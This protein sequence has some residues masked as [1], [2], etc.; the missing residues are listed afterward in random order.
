MEKDKLAFAALLA[1]VLVLLAPVLS[2]PG[3]VPGNFGDLFAYHY[4]L[5]QL[6]ASRLQSGAFPLWNPYIF[7]GLP[8]FANS[9]AATVYPGSVLFHILPLSAAFTFSMLLHLV[10]AGAGTYLL[11]RELR[12]ARWAATALAFS[13]MLSPFVAFRGAHGVPTLLCSLAYVPWTWLAL[14]AGAWRL[15]ALVFVLQFLSG[16]PQFMAANILGLGAVALFNGARPLRTLAAGGLVALALGAVQIVE[17]LRFSG[18]SVRTVWP[19][20]FASGYDWN[21][22]SW[23]SLVH[24]F[25]AG[26]PLMNDPRMLGTYQNLPS[27]FFETGI[28][29]AG[30][31][32]LA[33]AAWGARGARW[34]T[35]AVFVGLA[36]LGVGLALGVR[37][38]LYTF[39][40]EHTPL[41]MFRVPARFGLLVVWSVVLAAAWGLREFARRVPRRAWRAAALAFVCVDLVATD[42]PYFYAQ[43]PE[44]FIAP[45]AEVL[46]LGPDAAVAMG[47]K[48]AAPNKAMLY[49]QRGASGYEAYYLASAALYHGRSQRGPAADASKLYLTRGDTPEMR[50]LGIRRLIGEHPA[51]FDDAW[52]PA[53]LLPRDARARVPDAASPLGSARVVASAP[54]G[55]RVRVDAP[56]GPPAALVFAAAAYPG[57]KA[58]VRTA[59]GARAEDVVPFDGFLR[60]LDVP[61]GQSEV[62]TRYR[63]ASF[64][65]AL[66]ATLLSW[67]AFAGTGI[68][69]A[70]RE[71]LA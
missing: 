66:A 23:A 17:T 51:S 59:D 52:P 54:E 34:T 33:L 32:A 69:A 41:G 37:N 62:F 58:W 64:A 8:L 57:W 13:W 61:P 45:N 2:D 50:R 42:R 24:P 14:R 53:Y 18:Q 26:H 68:D 4:P 31:G 21:L 22:A 60:S 29:Y 49:R 27:F 5:R 28:F 40:S 48:V 16:H 71:A 1:P 70:R 46:A 44:A 56:A 9:Q 39:V 15:L 67:A 47:P 7:S 19:S 36:A 20:I 10:I 3:S 65:W 11:G 12:L 43:R 38:P 6:V 63:P 35:T 55:D 25:L 30:L